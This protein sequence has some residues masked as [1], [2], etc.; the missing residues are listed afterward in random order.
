MANTRDPILRIADQFRAFSAMGYTFREACQA[1]PD[2][3]GLGRAKLLEG[4]RAVGVVFDDQRESKRARK[5]P[6]KGKPISIR[7]AIRE[8]QTPISAQAVRYRVNVMAWP[9]DKALMT[10]IMTRSEAGKLG[11]RQ[12]LHILPNG[13]FTFQFLRP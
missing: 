11:A 3:I 9:M 6:T 4:L 12:G 10:P 1:C 2:K 7:Q 8:A 5:Y 13:Q